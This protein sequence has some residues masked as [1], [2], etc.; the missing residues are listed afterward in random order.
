MGK[1]DGW[2]M[3]LQCPPCPPPTPRGPGQQPREQRSQGWPTVAFPAVF[4][5][6]QLLW[7]GEGLYPEIGVPQGWAPAGR[8]ADLNLRPWDPCRQ[9]AHSLCLFRTCW[10]GASQSGAGGGFRQQGLVG[11]SE[12]Q[13]PSPRLCPRVARLFLRQEGTLS[14][15]CAPAC[16][17]E[18][19]WSRACSRCS[20]GHLSLPG[21][22]LSF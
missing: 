14:L 17:W 13:L 9:W 2:A 1:P 20:S 19:S 10:V 16:R 4:P 12:G 15:A 11:S 18:G 22:V 3:G 6:S 5:S 7:D 21:S 8:D